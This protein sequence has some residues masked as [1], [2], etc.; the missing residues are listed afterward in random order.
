MAALAQ[1]Q[2]LLRE[3]IWVFHPTLEMAHL[4]IGASMLHQHLLLLN[5]T[6][7]IGLLSNKERIWHSCITALSL[8]CFP[9]L[10]QLLLRLMFRLAALFKE[11]HNANHTP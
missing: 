3:Q 4:A 1:P 11:Q 8:C 5:S 2:P 6:Q 10:V 9:I 7:P